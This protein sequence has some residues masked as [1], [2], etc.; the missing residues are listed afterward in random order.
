MI[1][2]EKNILTQIDGKDEYLDDFESLDQIS[3]KSIKTILLILIFAPTSKEKTCIGITPSF[4]F[5]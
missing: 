1:F 4:K 3:L 5:E 2:Y